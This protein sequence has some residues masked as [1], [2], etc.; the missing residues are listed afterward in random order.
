MLTNSV[1]LV[2]QVMPFDDFRHEFEGAFTT[3]ELAEKYMQYLIAL[4]LEK[5]PQV[6]R[7]DF[8]V[9]K[10]ALNPTKSN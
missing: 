5:N 4:E 2:F 7:N 9:T 3:S 8:Y 10:V 1:Y 6:D